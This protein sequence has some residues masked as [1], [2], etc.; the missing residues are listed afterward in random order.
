MR[1]YLGVDIG[2]TA[3]KMGVVDEEG[4]VLSKRETKLSLSEGR[5]ALDFIADGIRELV[6]EEHS[7][8]SDYEGIAISAPGSIDTKKGRVAI[9]GGNV[10]GWSGTDVRTFMKKEFVLPMSLCNDGNCVALAESWTGAAKNHEDAVC[11]V[12]GTGIG[13]GI[14]SGGRLIEGSKG[15]AGEIGHYKIHA[16]GRECICG[17]RGCFERYASTAALIKSAVEVNDRWSSGR[18]LFRDAEDGDERALKLID[19]WTDEIAIGIASMVHIFNPDIV[20][21]GGGVSAQDELVIKP[22]SKKMGEFL[23]PDFAD[24]LSIRRTELGNDAGMVG[25]VKH[26]IDE[27]MRVTTQH[28]S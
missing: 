5:S 11:V 9:N 21:I 18:E 2:G 26:L 7:E 12:I 25:A 14:I 27:Q 13:G 20:L 19:Q 24:G 4:S 28:K 10:P 8:I 6:S 17:G 23:M 1:K 16:G 22:V 15:Y 3:I